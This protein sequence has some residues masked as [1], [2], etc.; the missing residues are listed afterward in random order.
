MRTIQNRIVRAFTLI[1]LLVVIS[2]IALLIALL[3]P[4][5]GQAKEAANNIVCQNQLRQTISAFLLFAEDHQDHLPGVFWVPTGANSDW[6][7]SWMGNETWAGYPYEGTLVALSY[8]PDAGAARKLYRCPSL[9]ESGLGSGF[10][11]NGNFDYASFHTFE[12]ALRETVPTQ[13]YIWRTYSRGGG[14][15]TGGR[16]GAGTPTGP[17]VVSTST[18]II[19]E[20]DPN[21][22]LNTD[23]IEPGHAG[24]DLMGSWHAKRGTNYAAIDSRVV[25]LSF[26]GQAPTASDWTGEHPLAGP[27]AYRTDQGFAFWNEAPLETIRTVLG[28]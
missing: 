10:G 24:G 8:I 26:P 7:R 20:E 25:H 11:S 2:I 27:V 9:P 17:A 4:A 18:P 22:N 12:G 28:P 5:L 13:S 19:V 3:L 1:E 6:K 23:N 21:Q 14:R 16:G 15:T